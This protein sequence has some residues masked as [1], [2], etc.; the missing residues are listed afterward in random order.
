MKQLFG[1]ITEKRLIDDHNTCH[2]HPRINHDRKRKHQTSPPSHLI[3]SSAGS[4]QLPAS[5]TKDSLGSACSIFFTWEVTQ[6]TP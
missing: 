3:N 6:E 1:R 4:Y 5:D 2:L